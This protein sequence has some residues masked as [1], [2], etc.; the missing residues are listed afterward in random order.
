MWTLAVFT[1]A[2]GLYCLAR[3]WSERPRRVAGF[4][5]GV[6]ALAMSVMALPAGTAVPLPAWTAAFGTMAALA[7]VGLAIEVRHPAAGLARA[8]LGRKAL[9]RVD[10]RSCGPHSP[11][12]HQIHHLLGALAM[13]YMAA[14]MA[15]PGHALP[16]PPLLAGALLLYF[17][18]HVLWSGT[19]IIIPAGATGAP[20]AART[21]RADLAPGCRV[22]M[23]TAMF[24][25][26]LCS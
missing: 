6:M 18:G 5:E 2:V 10:G 8:A 12:G 11:T 13:L 3:A 15:S 23:G 26:L 14:A 19:R 1:A 25:M 9:G 24:A 21:A 22:V 17:G 4:T 20:G 7:V 16:G